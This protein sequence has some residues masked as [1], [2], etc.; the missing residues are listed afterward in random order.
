MLA[1]LY[2]YLPAREGVL[3]MQ[4]VMV[5]EAAERFDELFWAAVGGEDIYIEDEKGRVV[6]LVPVPGSENDGEET[7]QP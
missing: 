3:T 5:D 6:R 2:F 4:Q 1:A 7:K